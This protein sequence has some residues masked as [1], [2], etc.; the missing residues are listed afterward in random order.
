MPRDVLH[1]D[2]WPY[3]E[4][5][6]VKATG[7]IAA[8]G[9]EADYNFDVRGWLHLPAAL[10]EAERRQPSAELA[11][12][13][14]LTRHADA[15]CG[16]NHALDSA[17]RPVAPT[18]EVFRDDPRRVGYD[19]HLQWRVC[20]GLRFFWAAGNSPPAL[21][22]VSCSH[23]STIPPPAALTDWSLDPNDAPEWC[24]LLRME[25]GDCLICAATLLVGVAP[26]SPACTASHLLHGSIRSSGAFPAAGFIPPTEVPDWF[27]LLDAA[28]QT[29][30]GPRLGLIP[31]STVP[32]MVDS[33][34]AA[35]VPAGADPMEF[36]EFDLRGF[37]VL[38]A[39]PRP[40]PTPA[41]QLS[42]RVS[43]YCC[44]RSLPLTPASQ[45]LC[46][47]L[48]C[49]RRDGLRVDRAGQRRAGH[50]GPPPLHRAG[51]LIHRRHPARALL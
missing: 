36:W 16:P 3:A 30:V 47:R 8:L 17:V 35:A 10:S 33:A 38:R 31:A 41:P 12:H 42:A 49:R 27:K 39:L 11:G 19:S 48:A 21:G 46:C 29:V 24:T 1:A 4:L 26:C 25:P 22:L 43:C 13:P 20:R 7:R 6:V 14:E 34:T 23:Q 2:R 28:A 9:R 45:T 15:L 5:P 50:L 37:L 32:A 40:P 44:L 18:G 51:R